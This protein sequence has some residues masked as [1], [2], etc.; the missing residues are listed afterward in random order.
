LLP[1]LRRD[2]TPQQCGPI[3]ANDTLLT[4][5]STSANSA[6]SLP[7]RTHA[8]GLLRVICQNWREKVW[9][10]QEGAES[11]PL[12]RPA[13]PPTFHL[14]P[15]LRTRAIQGVPLT[16]GL[17]ECSLAAFRCCCK[18]GSSQSRLVYPSAPSSLIVVV[19]CSC[20]PCLSCEVSSWFRSS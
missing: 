17:R 5:R 6:Y 20:S 12:S 14:S 19:S 1:L 13:S 16:F 9:V 15:P 4:N 3:P 8:C 10:H 18:G 11:Y 7:I 2:L